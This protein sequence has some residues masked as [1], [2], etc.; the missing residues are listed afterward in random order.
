LACKNSFGLFMPTPNVSSLPIP[1]PYQRGNFIVDGAGSGLAYTYAGVMALYY[2]GRLDALS[3]GDR[4]NIIEYLKALYEPY[5]G[6]RE[7]LFEIS[8]AGDE[9]DLEWGFL[10]FKV[11]DFVDDYRDWLFDAIVN[12]TYTVMRLEY[13]NAFPIPR[14]VEDPSV[15]VL[16]GTPGGYG[17]VYYFLHSFSIVDGIDFLN[18]SLTPRAVKVRENFFN[19]SIVF[20]LIVAVVASI[21]SYF[22]PRLRRIRET[23]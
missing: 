15:G 16:Y 12:A 20:G 18:N 10:L 23:F 6:F 3:L 8:A 11:L 5:H 22:L 4:L 19:L 2:L 13:D 21:L 9:A 17:G 14:R 7:Y 1:W